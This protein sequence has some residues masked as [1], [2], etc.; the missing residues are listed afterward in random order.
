MTRQSRSIESVRALIVLRHKLFIRLHRC[1]T[2][3]K[4]ST[5]LQ[6]LFHDLDN[7]VGKCVTFTRKQIFISGTDCHIAIHLLL[8]VVV[9]VVVVVL[10]LLL[11]LLLLLRA[12]PSKKP[13]APSFQI[14][15]E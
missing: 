13:N 14:G 1:T 12:T 9:V 15:S 8:V 6:V 11:L 3:H 7:V 5:T 4:T 2:R 10:L